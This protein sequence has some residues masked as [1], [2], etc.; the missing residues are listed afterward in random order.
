MLAEQERHRGTLEQ[1]R[2]EFVFLCLNEIVAELAEQSDDTPKTDHRGRVFLIPAKDAADE[3]SGALFAQLLERDG[4]AVISFPAGS[5]AELATLEPS[6]DDV[7]CVSALPPFAL[8]AAA[9]LC[10]QLRSRYPRVRIVAGIWGFPEGREQVLRRLEKST[11]VTVATSLAQA[12]EQTANVPV[13][14]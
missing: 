9:K 1:A 5:C 13:A 12:M 14:V 10:T 2:E 7:I 11:N 8:S 6:A 3:T 4:S